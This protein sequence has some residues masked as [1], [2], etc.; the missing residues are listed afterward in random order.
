MWSPVGAP[1][2]WSGATLCK[3]SSQGWA[4]TNLVSFSI[5]GH[6]LCVRLLS[7]SFL[8]LYHQLSWCLFNINRL[9]CLWIICQNKDIFPQILMIMALYHSNRKVR[10]ETNQF[11]NN[12]KKWQMGLY[13][14][15]N[16]CAEKDIINWVKRQ[17]KELKKIF[18]RSACDKWLI[19]RICEN[20]Y[21]IQKLNKN[22]QQP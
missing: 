1:V 7:F 5:L 15:K 13:W 14:I 21:K 18:T 20:I 3:E 12:V 19:S 6:C 16:F 17:P 8:F 11:I 2:W 4:L 9:L 10:Q 22:N